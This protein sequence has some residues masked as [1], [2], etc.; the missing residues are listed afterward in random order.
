MRASWF[1]F[2]LSTP[3][4]ALQRQA[5]TTSAAAC[6][7]PKTCLHHHHLHHHHPRASSAPRRQPQQHGPSST[8][9]ATGGHRQPPVIYHLLE[10]IERS[11]TLPVV[12]V[13]AQ[14]HV[15]PARGWVRGGAGRGPS[16]R[17]SVFVVDGDWDEWGW[18]VILFC[19]V[20]F[21]IL[22]FGPPFLFLYEGREE[23]GFERG[24]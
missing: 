9:T 7:K 20:L 14:D 19:F 5:K 8:T 2:R 21:V 23:G 17:E 16:K 11:L 6:A 15:C 13:A 1:P 22:F 24:R 18:W 12:A 4:A 10:T 3:P